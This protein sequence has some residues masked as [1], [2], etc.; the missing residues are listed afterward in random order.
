V[1]PELYGIYLP[2]VTITPLT[3]YWFIAS[4]VLY[5]SSFRSNHAPL[6]FRMPGN[7]PLEIWRMVFSYLITQMSPINHSD[8]STEALW[9]DCTFPYPHRTRDFPTTIQF[10]GCAIPCRLWKPGFKPSTSAL[11]VVQ[12]CRAWHDLGLE[13]L[14]HTVAFNTKSQFDILKVVLAPSYGRGRFVRQVSVGRAVRVLPSDIRLVLRG[15]PNIED[16]ESHEKY[17]SL[18]LISSLAG[19]RHSFF[20]GQD[21]P[22]LS[23]VS[24][25]NL[26]TFTNLQTLHIVAVAALEQIPVV[27][28]QLAVLVLKYD[29]RSA[30]HYDYVAR[31]TLPSLRV[32]VC[33][34]VTTPVLHV[35][36]TAFAQTV[37]LL[38][39]VQYDSWNIKPDTIEMPMLKCLIINWSPPFPG[40]TPRFN[41]SSHFHSLPALTTIRLEN[42][43][44]ALKRADIDSVAA[45]VECDLATLSPGSTV[46]PRLQI[47]YVGAE[48]GGVTGGDLER[49][50]ARRTAVGW[51]LHGRDGVWKVVGDGKLILA[52]PV[53]TEKIENSC[54]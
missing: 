42:I 7:L 48:L 4:F 50:L 22:Q 11:S 38:E 44:R 45:E 47:F 6:S 10:M 33:Q 54:D 28:P 46:A 12:V 23:R 9:K 39:I 52:E 49:C 27:L 15:C 1:T 13:F 34:W 40:Y 5:Q 31:W 41:M 14:Y 25:I 16:F 29:G 19:I 30:R 36:C 17:P 35:L 51:A 21:I 24:P 8:L 32:L 2:S 3:V 37:E 18:R 20:G 53:T 43:D 26:S